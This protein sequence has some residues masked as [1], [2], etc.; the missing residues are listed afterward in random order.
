[1]TELDKFKPVELRSVWPHEAGKFTPW[2]AEE[3]NLALLGEELKMDLVLTERESPVGI[4]SADLF[5]HE[6]TADCNVIIENQLEATDHDHLGKLITY[7]AGKSADILI[8][9][10]KDAREEHRQAV[11]WLNEHTDHNIGVFLVE[12]HLFSIGDSKP[13]PQF[14]VKECQN[15][16]MKSI[17]R[18]KGAINPKFEQ[19]F[20]FW[21]GFNRFVESHP[22]VKQEI[23]TRKLNGEDS[24]Y[25]FDFDKEKSVYASIN[26][27]NIIC[28][29]YI[30]KS[31]DLYEMFE[32]HK[33]DIEEAIGAELEYKLY[34]LSFTITYCHPDK[35]NIYNEGE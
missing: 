2:L 9:V 18:N 30:K 5:C 7:A 12:I 21:E 22:E 31:N 11:R 23:R 3:E 13:A 1:M 32:S 17:K 16:W 26:N 34:P 20:A 33:N 35:E 6:N 24:R 8:W 19:R 28:G 14:I 29:V 10:V 4:Y 15:D 27:K 25:L